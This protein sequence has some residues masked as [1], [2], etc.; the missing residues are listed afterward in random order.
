MDG[1]KNEKDYVATCS[2]SLDE[3]ITA[4]E[5]L[6]KAGEDKIAVRK[7]F[8]ELKCFVRTEYETFHKRKYF[9]TYIFENFHPLVE[10]IHMEALGDTRVNASLGEIEEAITNARSYML[11]WG[12]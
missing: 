6:I 10:N 2:R 4:V 12:K 7:V 9:G 3:K 8:K 5:E 11:D 1:I